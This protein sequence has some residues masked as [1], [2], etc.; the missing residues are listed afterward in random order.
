MAVR[1]PDDRDERRVLAEVV[2]DPESVARGLLAMADTNPGMTRGG[3][4][5]LPRAPGGEPDRE[6][7]LEAARARVV[8]R[9][10]LAGTN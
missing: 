5:A 7:L 8:I 6:A 3:Y 4:Y 10:N 2:E 1:R 9:I